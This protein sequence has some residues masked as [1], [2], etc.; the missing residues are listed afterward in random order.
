MDMEELIKE[1]FQLKEKVAGIC[2]D[3]KWIKKIGYFISA[4]IVA[5][6]IVKLFAG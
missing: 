4:A 6:L 1:F 3:I 2:N 5:Q